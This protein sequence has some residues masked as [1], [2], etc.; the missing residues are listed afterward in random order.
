MCI[1]SSDQPQLWCELWTDRYK[2][3]SEVIA[4]YTILIEM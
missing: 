1:S 2:L 3:R 4:E